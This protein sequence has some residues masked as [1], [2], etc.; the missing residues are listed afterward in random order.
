M[1]ITERDPGQ[2]EPKRF[3]VECEGCSFECATTGREEAERI[4]DAHRGET[5]H[6]LV[7]LE[8]PP[9]M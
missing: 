4:G 1:A 9:S 2:G 5:G 8:L 3:L 6:D 7:A